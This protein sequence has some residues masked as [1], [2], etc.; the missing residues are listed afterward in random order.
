MA[1]RNH[2]HNGDVDQVTKVTVV[3][4]VIYDLTQMI[5]ADCSGIRPAMRQMKADEV[6]AYY[7]MLQKAVAELGIEIKRA[8]ETW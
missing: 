7:G 3:P 4:G 8:M 6:R 2:N 5:G 1:R